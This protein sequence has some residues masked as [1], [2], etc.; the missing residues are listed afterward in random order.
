MR[1]GVPEGRQGLLIEQWTLDNIHA[2]LER[3][4]MA[5]SPTKM[6]KR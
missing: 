3:C 1:E 4:G 2:D 5:G 6:A